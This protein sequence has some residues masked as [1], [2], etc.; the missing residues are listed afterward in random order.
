MDHRAEEEPE[1]GKCSRNA[2]LRRI[3]QVHIVCMNDLYG[4]AL[5]VEI[6]LGVDHKVHAP[7]NAKKGMIE[8]HRNRAL[9]EGE[10]HLRRGVDARKDGEQTIRQD[11]V[12]EEDP[13]ANDDDAE[14]HAPVTQYTI[15][16][17]ED[18][19]HE[20]RTAR[21]GHAEARERHDKEHEGQ[22]APPSRQS[23]SKPERKADDD[24]EITCE[25]VWILPC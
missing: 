11:W 12:K 10:P 9:P 5:Q 7:A 13:R 14:K 2:D 3:V 19:D 4:C 18:T 6:V 23:G 8:N 24:I 22:P 21:I 17:Q 25:D 15:P 16:R 20:A 1:E